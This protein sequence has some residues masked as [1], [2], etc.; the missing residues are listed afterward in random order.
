MKNILLLASIYPVNHDGYVGTN[1]CHYFAKEWIKMGYNVKVLFFWSSF[2]KVYYWVAKPFVSKLR[3]KTSFAIP[4]FTF[5]KTEIYSIDGVEIILLPVDKIFPHQNPS[6]NQLLK[7]INEG[8]SILK[9]KD[10]TPDVITAHFLNPQLKVL[11]LIKRFYPKIRTCFVF[12]EWNQRRMQKLYGD[13]YIEYLKSIDLL[14]FR[15]TIQQ[16]LY[17]QSGIV[18]KD[19][20]IC[21]S[22]VPEEYIS[23]TEKFFNSN[24]NKF[25][26]LGS[27]YRL[28]N[29][30]ITIQALSLAYP[31]KD[32]IFD[33]IGDGGELKNLKK[34]TKKLELENNIVF[35]GRL[36]RNEAQKVLSK[37]DSFIMVSSPEV[38][39]L[40]YI[41]AM[42]HGLITIGSK[43]EGIDGLIVNEE[44][45]FLVRP[46]DINN[47][48]STLVSIK[49]LPKKVLGK[50]SLNAKSTAVNHTDKK[51]AERYLNHLSKISSSYCFIISLVTWIAG[52]C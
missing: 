9:D 33:I 19:T 7:L 30:D 22:G 47:L 18:H 43:G 37:A 3:A 34:L 32:F 52:N 6:D 41:E 42:S 28:K 51:A 45:G 23:K 36:S 2:P 16:Q 46:R 8:V 14:G 49:K 11:Y 15:S 13:K 24:I 25:V 38:L 44:N 48:V 26:Y 27:L 10:F 17:S 21:Y 31:D 20:F 4:T 1:I 12:H 35:H 40:V 29:V 50:I 5:D 39:G